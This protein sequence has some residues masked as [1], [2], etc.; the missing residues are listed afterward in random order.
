MTYADS[1]VARA[2]RATRHGGMELLERFLPR[3]N[4][5]A[6]RR[7]FDLGPTDRTN[8]SRLSPYLTTRLLTQKDVLDAVLAQHSPDAVE[9]FIHQI[10]WRTYFKGWLEQRPA[11]W[12]DWLADCESLATTEAATRAEQ[13]VITPTGIDCF[14]AWAT[15]LIETGWLHNHARMWF[16]SIWIFT[17]GLPWQL[18]AKFFFTHLLDADPA[19]NTLSW[20]WVAGIQTKGKHYLA[21]RDNIA[22]FT[23]GRFPDSADLAED[24]PPITDDRDYPLTPLSLPDPATIPSTGRIGVLLH[25]EDCSFELPLNRAIQPVAV[26][27]GW[28]F[29][30]NQL[31]GW[32]PTVTEFRKEA[33]NDAAERAI[34]RWNCTHTDLSAATNWV[35]AIEDWALTERLDAILTPHLTVGPWRDFLRPRLAEVE[36]PVHEVTRDWDRQLW[37]HAT[38]GFFPFRKHIP[39]ALEGLY[40]S[41]KTTDLRRP[42]F[43]RASSSQ[44]TSLFSPS[45]R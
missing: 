39:A 14:D 41:L 2:H 26:A 5:Y 9:S 1:P 38:K 40:L 8:V 6:D 15:E 44:A 30:F 22:R 34:R 24:A 18:G 11:V 3:A 19:S 32:S 21:R 4:N 20:R 27:V 12:T 23:E 17:F 36:I 45:R 16:A 10:C 37:P 31:T 25:G 35:E 28:P 7:N 43:I 13:A 29:G 42:G 33:L